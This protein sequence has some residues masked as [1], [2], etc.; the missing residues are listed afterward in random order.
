MEKIF[1]RKTKTN[2][3]ATYNGVK[4]KGKTMFKAIE[5]AQKMYLDL[6]EE[7]NDSIDALMYNLAQQQEER[8]H[9]TITST[10]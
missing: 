8:T 1:I 2:Y 9:D 4:G 3:L 5:R 6:Q 7:P 10:D